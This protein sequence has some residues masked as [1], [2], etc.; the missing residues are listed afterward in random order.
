MSGP[1]MLLLTTFAPAAAAD[2]ALAVRQFDFQHFSH[3]PVAA[4]HCQQHAQQCTYDLYIDTRN[5]TSIVSSIEGRQ[6]ANIWIYH[7][8]TVCQ[9]A[10]SIER[11]YG[12]YGDPFLAE[13]RRLL[14][15]LVQIRQ[16]EPQTWRMLSGG[17]GYAY[18]ELAAGSSGAE[19]L[20]YLDAAP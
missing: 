18:T 16:L 13:E 11:G 3:H 10:L 4:Q 19:L 8:I 17:A 5:Y 15:W 6:T 1:D 2:L 9:A 14:G 7:T 20:A 12:G